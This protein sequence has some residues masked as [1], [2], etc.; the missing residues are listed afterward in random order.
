LI[1]L[2]VVIA[3]I[4][5]LIGL[6][7]PAVQKVREAAARSQCSNNLK[8]MALACHNYHDV[9]KG[10][11]PARIARDAYATWPV[12]IMPYIEQDA[13]Y[14]QWNIQ[15]GF[16]SQ[17]ATARLTIV[18]MFFC[19]S[20]NRSTQISPTTENSSCGTG[21]NFNMDGACGDYAGCAGT[22]NGNNNTRDANGVI[23]VGHVVT[24]TISPQNVPDQPN[25]N[26][27]TNPL[28]PITAFKP[29][30]KLQSILDGTSNTFMIGEKYVR[31]GHWGECGD[32]DQAY[33]SGLSYN[34]AQRVAGPNYPLAIAID[35]QNGN[36]SDMF[37]GPHTGICLFAFADA[38]VHAIGTNID[39]VNLGYLAQRNDRQPINYQY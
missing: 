15:Q 2:L 23:I 11:P 5:I 29:Y 35:D 3:I 26:P 8:Q 9:Y 12:L 25:P 1:E 7:L 39:Q 4:A 6:L 10:L 30:I 16:S 14:K 36:H 20:R 37:G 17:N 19:P 24:P 13:V 33:Y 27:P 22:A 38:S 32:G 31:N 34:S 18:P 28:V 21:G